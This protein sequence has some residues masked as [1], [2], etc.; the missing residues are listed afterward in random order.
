MPSLIAGTALGEWGGVDWV[1]VQGA[2]TALTLTVLLVTVLVAGRQLR[3]TRQM[4]LDQLQPHVVV[5][6][7]PSAA[8]TLIDLTVRNVGVTSAKNVKIAVEPAFVTTLD[9][10][11]MKLATRSCSGTAYQRSLPDVRSAPYSTVS[12]SALKRVCRWSTRC[13]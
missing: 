12:R 3:E 7:E 13:A 10:Q 6:L 5:D 4:R 2:A 11:G 1:A 9:E 8:R